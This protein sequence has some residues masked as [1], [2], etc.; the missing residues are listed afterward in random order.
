MEET[1]TI[2]QALK[3]GYEYCI[4]GNDD[5]INYLCDLNDTELEILTEDKLDVYLTEK[6]CT[7]DGFPNAEDIL[8]NLVENMEI[9]ECGEDP[10]KDL[11]NEYKEDL[12]ILLDK[13]RS[14]I[15]K[16]NTTNTYEITEIKLVL[17]K[18][19]NN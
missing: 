15:L 17:N 12:Q 19:E 16:E 18:E 1:K 3:E 7:I 13:M 11:A 8:D 9:H 10:M 5:R 6:Q 14:Q 4:I 2:E